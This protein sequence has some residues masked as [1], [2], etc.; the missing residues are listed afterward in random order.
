MNAEAIPAPHEPS[1]K[2]LLSVYPTAAI[3]AAFIA[4]YAA[5]RFVLEYWRADDRGGL[6]GLS[7]SQLIG[8]A[9]VGVAYFIHRRRLASTQ[10]P[11]PPAAPP[12]EAEA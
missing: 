4:L 8:V 12:A 6:L 3:W 10:A 7:T 11:T 5:G 9:L 2:P 1:Q